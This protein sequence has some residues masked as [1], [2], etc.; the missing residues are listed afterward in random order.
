MTVKEV[1]DFL[2]DFDEKADVVVCDW[3]DSSAIRV[4]S[5]DEMFQLI[6]E[7]EEEE[8]ED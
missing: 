8:E 7:E 6:W 2:T 5:G 1:I 4:F 3:G